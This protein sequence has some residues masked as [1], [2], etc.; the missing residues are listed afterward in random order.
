MY[1]QLIK[2]FCKIRKYLMLATGQSKQEANDI[3]IPVTLRVIE[4]VLRES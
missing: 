3:L 2:E 4:K 1:T